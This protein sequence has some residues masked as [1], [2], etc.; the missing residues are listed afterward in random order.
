MKLLYGRRPFLVCIVDKTVATAVGKCVVSASPL[1][2]KEM[3]DFVVDLTLSDS[4]DGDDNHVENQQ[5]QNNG[6]LFPNAAPQKV[7]SNPSSKPSVTGD[8]SV[9]NKE[10]RLEEAP[11]NISFEPPP[12]KAYTVHPDAGRG[13]RQAPERTVNGIQASYVGPGRETIGEVQVRALP[14]AKMQGTV[15]QNHDRGV[16]Q[17][18]ERPNGMEAANTGPGQ[19]LSGDVSTTEQR[20]AH[21]STATASSP[22]QGPSIQKKKRPSFRHALMLSDSGDLSNA[23]GSSPKEARPDTP[24]PP[25]GDPIFRNDPI[26]T[27]QEMEV[28]WLGVESVYCDP[29]PN[30]STFQWGFIWEHASESLRIELRKLSSLGDDMAKDEEQRLRALVRMDDLL[31]VRRFE[32][33]REAFLD[34]LIRGFRRKS[35]ALHIARNA[36]KH[37]MRQNIT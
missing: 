7:A 28:L 20:G 22:A 32:F 12:K 14:M 2:A 1:F 24:P 35:M 21:V 6:V 19:K 31:V 13:V 16:R 15:P 3:S 18:P 27:A 34:A 9:G 29:D 5:K 10:K 8:R 4:D 17:A 11:K 33:L 30:C 37:R 26:L 23:V 36:M 25:P